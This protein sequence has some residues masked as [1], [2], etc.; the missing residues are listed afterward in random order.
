MNMAIV[1]LSTCLFS[2]SVG[3]LTLSYS[4]TKI[5]KQYEKLFIDMLVLEKYVNEIEA[6]QIKDDENVH[7]ENFVKFLSDS[8]DWAYQYIE[9]VQSGLSK[10][11]S[12]VDSHIVHFDKYGDT[13]STERPDYAA[14]LQISKSYKD[15]VKL[16]PVEENK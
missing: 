7:R 15:L 3:Y 5:R 16:L 13:I 12:D 2:I 8:R 11:I 1:I 6:S 9:E 4:F 14:M 10:F